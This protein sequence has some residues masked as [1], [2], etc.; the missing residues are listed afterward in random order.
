MT[1]RTWDGPPELEPLLVPLED[2]QPHPRNPRQGDVGAMTL[3]LEAFGQYRAA[4]V[5][6]SSGYILAGS[7]LWR[8]AKAMGWSHLAVIRRD[9]SDAEA[10]QLLV[11]DNRVADRGSYDQAALAD[12]LTELAHAGALAPGTGYDLE[13]LDDLLADL[14]R[15]PLPP[16]ASGPRTPSAPAQAP[17]PQE[18]PQG[19]TCPHCGGAL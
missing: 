15:I 14:D 9:L 11:A 13:D 19:R 6:A 3:S 4:I 8:A 2:V 10:A 1:E 18:A 17:E 5:Q 7:H 16:P 12:L